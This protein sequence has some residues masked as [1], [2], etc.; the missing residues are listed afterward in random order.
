MRAVAHA[1]D[2]RLDDLE[3]DVGFEQREA[4]FAERVLDVRFGQPTFT[5]DRAKDVLESVAESVEH[6]DRPAKPGASLG[7]VDRRQRKPLS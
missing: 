2:E 6:T 5:P 1:I 4:N 3:V 7:D